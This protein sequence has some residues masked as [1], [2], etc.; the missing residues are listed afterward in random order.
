V[1]HN[2]I[3]NYQKGGVVV[4]G[5]MPPN[6]GPASHAEVAY[7]EID[8]IG[9][10]VLNAQNGIQISR[11]AVANVHHNVVKD[12]IYLP[13]AFTAEEILIFQVSSSQIT[14]HHNDVFH[15]GDGIALIDS[16]NIE[17][18][19]NRSH[20]QVLYDGLFADTDSMNNRIEYNKLTDNPEFDCD[21]VSAGPYNAPAMVAN[22]WIQ[23][24]GHTENRPGLCKHATP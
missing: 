4:D 22:P 12:N 19:W 7:N 9:P 24:L 6:T 20:D 2:L 14:V 11:G 10:T 18:G 23:D 1:V 8:G 13:L 3:D 5:Q 17:V 16:Q 21:D 15:N